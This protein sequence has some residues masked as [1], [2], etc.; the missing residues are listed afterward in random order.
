MSA[1]TFKPRHEEPAPRPWRVVER[2]QMAAGVAFDV[3]VFWGKDRAACEGWMRKKGSGRRTWY[4]SP[5]GMDRFDS[6]IA[7]P[8]RLR[9]VD[10]QAPRALPW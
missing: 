10:P 6:D 8:R 7:P 1:P 9:V 3:T 2:R 5:Y 4:E